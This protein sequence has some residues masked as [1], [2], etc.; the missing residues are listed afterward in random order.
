MWP[1]GPLTLSHIEASITQISSCRFPYADSIVRQI[2]SRGSIVRTP[3]CGFHR[4]DKGAPSI[5]RIPLSVSHR[6]Y[7]I[8]RIQSRAFYRANADFILRIPSDKFHCVHSIRRIPL[9]EFHRS[10][11]RRNRGKLSVS[12]F[13]YSIFPLCHRE[14][15][16]KRYLFVLIVITVCGGSKVESR[17]LSTSALCILTLLLFLSHV[18]CIIRPGPRP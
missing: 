13:F 11:S 9:C 8:E 18:L 6:T 4:A 17:G 5:E 12:G 7:S 10:E 3:L 14:A 15:D 2:L 1:L 16:Q